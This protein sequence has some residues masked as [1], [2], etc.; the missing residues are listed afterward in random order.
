MK[1]NQNA[2]PILFSIMVL[3]V[4]A[5]PKEPEP[6]YQIKPE[7]LKLSNKNNNIHSS[8]RSLEESFL[9]IQNSTATITYQ[10]DYKTIEHHLILIPKNLPEMSYFTEWSFCPGSEV[11]DISTKCEIINKLSRKDCTASQKIENNRIKL[12]FKGEIYNE[13]TLIINYKYNEKTVNDLLYKTESVTIPMIENTIFC[14]YKFIIPDGYVN[15]GLENNIL[16]KKSNTI[17]TFY[18]QCSGTK[19]KD[20]IRYSPQ[21]ATFMADVELSVSYP[22]KFTNDVNLT[23]PRSYTGGKLKNSIYELSSLDNSLYNEEDY[24]YDNINYRINVKAAGEEKIGIKIHTIFTNDLNEEFR[25]YFPES[26]YEIDLSKIDQEIIDKANEIIKEK[27]DKPIYYKLGKFVNSYMTYD[28]SY[29]GRDLTL[30]EIYEGK[31]GVC[32]HYTKLYNA[33]LNAVGIK[34]LY[35]SGWSFDG[36]KTTGNWEDMG[37][38]WTAALIDDKWIELDSTNGLFEGVPASLVLMDFTK[39]S[40]SW[41]YS[42]KRGSQISAKKN[43]NIKII[44]IGKENKIKEKYLIGGGIGFGVC[45]I[46]FVLFYHNRR[47]NKNKL[48][49][50]LIEEIKV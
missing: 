17:Y 49:S 21:K 41:G 46:L 16:T 39:G 30:K 24:I 32:E 50:E 7:T 43:Y 8:F 11:N 27:S 42:E 1:F 6:M 19:Q 34:T 15:L 14:D 38:A 12:L 13:D 18:G 5:P 36:N 9:E 20:T 25:V 47:K 29:Y 45:F 3:I 10:E 40:F 48:H 2:I 31:T 26:H 22:P 33:M 35:I 23:F 4:C 28:L 37:H 44:S